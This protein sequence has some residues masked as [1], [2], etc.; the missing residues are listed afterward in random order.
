MAIANGY[1]DLASFKAWRAITSTNATD[2]GAIEGL[3]ELASR[4]ID[5]ET[6]R[7]FYSRSETRYFSVPDGLELHLDD[8]L[9]TIST[10]GLVNGDA[11]VITSTYYHL[12][13]KNKAPYHTI[14]LKDS[15]AYNW[16]QDSNGDTEYVISVAGTWGY[17]ATTPADIKNA[18]LMIASSA[19]NRMTGENQTGVARI[20]AAGVVITPE[21]IPS[22]AML[23]IRGYKRRL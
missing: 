4:F 12:L 21:D 7:T 14:K 6:K 10:N 17:S 23:I 3:I 20:T 18:C 19:Y 15:S 22:S 13:P 5:A 1:C 16:T 9:L 11:T 2:D 8:D